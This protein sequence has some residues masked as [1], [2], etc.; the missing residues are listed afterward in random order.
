MP[1]AAVASP[2][3]QYPST[4]LQAPAGPGSGPGLDGT[5]QNPLLQPG[6]TF[7]AFT[8]ALP[9]LKPVATPLPPPAAYPSFL[10]PLPDANLAGE[11]QLAAMVGQLSELRAASHALRAGQQVVDTRAAVVERVASQYDTALTAVAAVGGTL[12][13]VFEQAAQAEADAHERA[14]LAARDPSVYRTQ[15]ISLPS[16]PYEPAASTTSPTRQLGSPTSAAYR[17]GGSPNATA[18]SQ[19]QL[20]A[21]ALTPAGGSRSGALLGLSHMLLDLAVNNAEMESNRA[22]SALSA[23]SASYHG[24]YGAGDRSAPALLA[25]A[26]L[27]QQV[28][29]SPA[30]RRRHQRGSGGDRHRPIPGTL[31]AYE[32]QQAILAS[33]AASARQRLQDDPGVS[34]TVPHMMKAQMLSPR[35]AAYRGNM[36]GRSTQPRWK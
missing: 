6:S 10:P 30:R 9:P 23:L 36:T 34:A 27:L 19:Q 13:R 1:P 17:Y 24:Q 2:P 28:M 14:A 4:Y 8:D 25:D 32:E 3:P 31:A 26:L 16:G 35:G 18:P 22:V 7:A 15:P 5:R 20:E 33:R 21:A 29:A 12:A 11:A